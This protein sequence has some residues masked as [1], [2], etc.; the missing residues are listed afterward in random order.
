M[1]ANVRLIAA[2][3][4][5]LGVVTYSC[6]LDAQAAG[7]T[8]IASSDAL[9]AGKLAF[10]V[11][12]QQPDAPIWSKM[13]AELKN[14]YPSLQ[15]EWRAFP[16]DTFLP[17][18]GEAQNNHTGPDVVFADNFAQE[19]PLVQRRAGRIMAG[20]PR[21]GERG[22]WMIMADS[23]HRQ[24]AEAF[25]I[26]LERPKDW[27]PTQ[28]ITQH[29]TAADVKQIRTIATGTIEAFGNFPVNLPQENLDPDI[30]SFTWNWVRRRVNLPLGEKQTYTA[31]VEQVGGNARLAFVAVS[32]LER[33]QYSFGL[34]ES[35][36]LLRKHASGWKIL[37]LENNVP[38]VTVSQMVA[39]FDEL[40][41]DNETPRD[42]AS[43]VLLSPADAASV[44]RFPRQEIAF[45]EHSSADQL[46]AIESQFFIPGSEEWSESHLAWVHPSAEAAGITRLSIPFGVGKQPH[47][48]RVLIVNKAGIVSL[49][50]WRT[51]NFTN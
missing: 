25:F 13:V 46:S 51:I 24:A 17:A 5:G 16:R 44:A 32:T 43:V 39:R 27:Q 23:A 9:R 7:S 4:L 2:V 33:G 29:L 18:L 48:W 10:W 40:G 19:G 35:F 41:M 15:V 37:Y 34:M 12:S 45:E 22:W 31:A 28:P 26:W 1:S 3:A 8:K 21:H 20:S 6:P 30:A 36:L 47:R 42:H 49:S 11:S 50:E 14:D 38:A